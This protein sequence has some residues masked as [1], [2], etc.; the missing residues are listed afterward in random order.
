MYL[1][2][3]VLDAGTFEIILLS[4]YLLTSSKFCYLYAGDDSLN[5]SYI[6]KSLDYAPV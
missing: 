5:S 4:R 2:V 6:T 1:E 3:A